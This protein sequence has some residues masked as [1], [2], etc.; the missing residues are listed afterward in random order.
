MKLVLAADCGGDAGSF[1]TQGQQAAGWE[2][3]KRSPSEPPLIDLQASNG[4]TRLE[5]LATVGNVTLHRNDAVKSPTSVPKVL[6]LHQS[7][8]CVG[9]TGPLQTTTTIPRLC[10]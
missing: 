3:E 1:P 10:S 2:M 6:I 9:V 8:V 5:S 7:C 4:K